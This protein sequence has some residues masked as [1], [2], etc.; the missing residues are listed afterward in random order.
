MREYFSKY[1]QMIYWTCFGGPRGLIFAKL[2][3]VN[4]DC[5][6]EDRTVDVKRA[7][8]GTVCPHTQRTI[9]GEKSM[10]G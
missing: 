4:N 2:M 7:H 5:V 3:H 10:I 9:N 8:E 1:W 6:F